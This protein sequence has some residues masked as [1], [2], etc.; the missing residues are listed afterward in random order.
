MIMSADVFGKTLGKTKLRHVKIGIT[1]IR[2]NAI[3]SCGRKGRDAM[4]ILLFDKDIQHSL[5]K[6]KEYS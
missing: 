5:N 3:T 1:D 2:Q 4:D 6:L